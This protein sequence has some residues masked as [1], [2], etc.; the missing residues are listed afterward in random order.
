MITIKFLHV[1]LGVSSLG[2]IAFSYVNL[3]YHS[4]RQQ[5]QLL[6]H[7]LNNSLFL[8]VPLFFILISQFISGYYLVILQ[9]RLFSTPWIKIAFMALA[10]VFML[11]LLLVVVKSIHLNR[12]KKALTERFYY[13]WFYHLAYLSIIL[14]MIVIIHDAVMKSTYF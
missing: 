3:A 7:S 12:L 4:H 11:W 9:Q 1:L 13:R 10:V 2:L 8:D 6:R 5:V 14:L